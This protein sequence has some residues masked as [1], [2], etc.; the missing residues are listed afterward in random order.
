MT[1]PPFQQ[2]VPVPGVAEELSDK[3]E[4][5]DSPDSPGSPASP[6]TPSEADLYEPTV[7]DVPPVDPPVRPE[8]A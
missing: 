5:P 2:P 3:L 4:T 6:A 7:I 1:Q 8:D